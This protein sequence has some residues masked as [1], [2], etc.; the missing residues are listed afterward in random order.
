ML[1]K[2]QTGAAVGTGIQTSLGMGERL[3]PLA[4]DEAARR[5]PDSPDSIRQDPTP[6]AA[7][8]LPRPTP[9]VGAECVSSACSDLSGGRGVTRVPCTLRHARQAVMPAGRQGKR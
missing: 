3:R 6:L 9:E 7:I 1:R 2:G 5:A 8:T 4:A